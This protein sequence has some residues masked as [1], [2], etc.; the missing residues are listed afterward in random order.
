MFQ[1]VNIGTQISEALAGL[2]R[3]REVLRELPEDADPRRVVSL[4][5]ITG[6]VV[7]DGVN[8]AYD[9]G[10]AVLH[11]VSF[12][13]EPGTVTALV[14]PSGS[15]KSTIIGLIAA[16]HGPESGTVLV[17]GVD[18]ST[19][20]LD[21]YRTVGRGASGNISI[22]RDH[23]GERRVCPAQC[24]QGTGSGSL[25]DRACRRVRRRL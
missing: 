25:P 14:G 20:R 19:V 10:K 4:P 23:L 15:G 3:T 17:D 5:P 9:T 21:S 6:Q 2:E 13:S 12:R 1:L 7:F 16:F 11:E 24:D 18:L 22:R 8:F